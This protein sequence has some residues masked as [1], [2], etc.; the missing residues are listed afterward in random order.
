MLKNSNGRASFQ[1][2]RNSKK[3]PL[4]KI[5]GTNGRNTDITIIIEVLPPAV[6]LKIA[7]QKII[8]IVPKRKYSI[9][10]IFECGFIKANFRKSC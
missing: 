5:D 8:D 1:M 10:L 7:S 2:S 6:L 4:L 9:E 3:I